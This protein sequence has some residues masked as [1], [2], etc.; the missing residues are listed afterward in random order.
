[1]S[2]PKPI[3]VTPPSPADVINS[4]R[5]GIHVNVPLL[6]GTVVLLVVM[7]GGGWFIRGYFLHANSAV[8]LEKARRAETQGEIDAAL[9]YYGEYLEFSRIAGRKSDEEL[10]HRADILARMAALLERLPENESRIRSLYQTYEECLRLNRD[11]PEMRLRFVAL[12]MQLPRFGDALSHLAILEETVSPGYDLAEVLYLKGGCLEAERKFAESQRAFLGSIRNWPEQAAAYIRLA[13]LWAAHPDDVSSVAEADLPSGDEWQIVQEILQPAQKQKSVAVDQATE[14]VLTA[15]LEHRPGATGSVAAARF[16]MVMQS[17]ED[18]LPLTAAEAGV[19]TR[20]VFAAAEASVEPADGTGES[21][22]E[23]LPWLE[24][25]TPGVPAFS[26]AD[27]D[28]HVTREE[29][30]QR[31]VDGD[32]LTRLGWAEKLLARLP[33]TVES[34][35]E[36]SLA[37]V[38]LL[39][40]RIDVV[41]ML[42]PADLPAVVEQVREQLKAVKDVAD[43]DLRLLFARMSLDQYEP[44]TG[45]PRDSLEK[46]RHAETRLRNVLEA[47]DRTRGSRGSDSEVDWSVG[48]K[49]LNT[50]WLEIELRYELAGILLDQLALLEP[51]QHSPMLAAIRAESTRLEETGA[52]QSYPAAIHVRELLLDGK[53]R[54]AAVLASDAGKDLAPQSPLAR[55]LALLA[56]DGWLQIG[57]RVAAINELRKQLQRDP[58]WIAGRER[59]AETLFAAGHLEEA[60]AEFRRLSAV[61]G[62]GERLL[63]LLLIRNAGVAPAHRKWDEPEAIIAGL[64]LDANATLPDLLLGVEYHMLRAATD[65]ALTENGDKTKAVSQLAVAEELL[66]SAQRRFPEQLPVLIAQARFELQRFDVPPDERRTRAETLL[67]EYRMKSG[68]PVDA[69]LL[70]A[71][72]AVD[73]DGAAAVEQ[74]LRLS[75]PTAEIAGDEKVRLLSGLARLATRIGNLQAARDLWSRAAEVDPED[76]VSRLAILQLLLEQG[77]NSDFPF[78]EQQWSEMLE[79]VGRIEGTESGW[80]AVLKARRRLESLAEDLGERTQQL[81]E[82]A[83]WLKSVERTRPGWSEVSRLRGRIADLLGQ[84]DVAIAAYREAIAQGDRSPDIIRRVAI[85]HFQRQEYGEADR[86]LQKIAEESAEP[87]TGDLARLAWK[88]TWN[89]HEFDRA[90]GMARKLTAESESAEDYITLALLQFARGQH[91]PET[92]ALLRKAAW[93]LAP[94]TTPPWVALVGYYARLQRWS[95]AEVA[96]AA[97]LERLPSAPRPDHLLAVGSLYDILAAA[98]SADRSSFVA[99]A[100]TAFEAALVA[101]PDDEFVIA[102]TAEHFLQHNEARRSGPLLETLLKPDRPT[103][104]GV[105]TWARM[106]LARLVASGGR[107]EDLRQAIELLKAAVDSGEDASAENLRLQLEF[108]ERLPGEDTR[109]PRLKLLQTLKSQS[110]LSREE[111]LQIAELLDAAGQPAEALQAF[112]TLL[113]TQPKFTRARVAYIASLLRQRTD[114]PV[115][116]EAARVQASLLNDMEPRSWQTAQIRSQ[117]EAAIGKNEQALQIVQNFVERRFDLAG[118]QPLATYL[119]QEPLNDLLSRLAQ[120]L[121]V[122]GQREDGKLLENAADLLSQGQRETAFQQLLTGRS[123]ELL[124]ELRYDSLR[125]AALLLEELKLGDPEPY[126]RRFA[127]ESP[128]PGARLDLASFLVRRNRAAEALQICEE[129]W[130]RGASGRAAAVA[131]TAL[132]LVPKEPPGELVAWRERLAMAADNPAITD[133]WMVA[134]LLGELDGLMGSEAA[135]IEGYRKAVAANSRDGIAWNNLAYLLARRN[136]SSED[137]QEAERAIAEAIRVA[138]P[139]QAA[140]DT[141]AVVYLAQGKAAEAL[142]TVQSSVGSEAAGALHFRQAE[143]LWRLGRILEARQ[144]LDRAHRDGWRLDELSGSDRRVAE[145]CVRELQS[146]E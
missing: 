16:L 68:P 81:A 5:P 141:R 69:A 78:P 22:I 96:I 116:L 142:A 63:E 60:I 110:T 41:R 113:E 93:D 10:R 92:E 47:L 56:V 3:I 21:G 55:Q 91:G 46:L 36:V 127:A 88:V 57:N 101:A 139:D 130:N 33:E 143:C 53:F 77:G 52:P 125:Q 111:S 87:L 65:H 72:I 39:T 126:F 107:F 42:R 138:G 99:K 80:V 66:K 112:E 43:D 50:R 44:E 114:D 140:L 59:L 100:T 134:N 8:Y 28:G 61:P 103:T 82:A 54:E 102:A 105:R 26:D 117:I 37:L 133:R 58:A 40:A 122:R 25:W 17:V 62:F 97:A 4:L 9:G 135:S 108:L 74:L 106:R 30:Q 104:P 98:N 115:L 35:Q 119:E 120:E 83:E 11:Q 145:M 32:A 20:A 129:V 79:D 132:R 48:V 45:E 2:D 27:F 64:G 19:R 84:P 136:A 15:L 118:E 23:P 38:E 7:A 34:Q 1:M 94:Q 31:F 67:S 121:S 124:N 18:R 144:A 85:H 13:Q 71:Q 6:V 14:A 24:R 137:L 95:D 75:E 70:E 89:R 146:T 131:V 76:L 123:A 86:L 29:M 12:L 109:G 51:D 73:R 128:A 90:I 49:L